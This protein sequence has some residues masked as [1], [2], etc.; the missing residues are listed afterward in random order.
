MLLYGE[1]CSA[2]EIMQLVE[3]TC[4]SF[5]FWESRRLTEDLLFRP[6]LPQATFRRETLPQS[7]HSAP[8]AKLEHLIFLPATPA[9]PRPILPNRPLL[10][11]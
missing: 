8:L 11:G 2:L 7:F 4:N 3:K 9:G 10:L 5:V 6:R 1:L